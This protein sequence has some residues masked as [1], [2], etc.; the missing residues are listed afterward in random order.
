M[1]EVG[2]S[3][4]YFSLVRVNVDVDVLRG[5]GQEHEYHRVALFGQDVPVGFGQG[6]QEDTVAHHAPVDEEV[7]GIATG[8]TPRRWRHES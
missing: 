8:A 5:K 1:D 7:L 2:L 3:E 4:P 6:M